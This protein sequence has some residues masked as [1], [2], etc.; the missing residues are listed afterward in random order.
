MSSPISCFKRPRLVC[1][2]AQRGRPH[3]SLAFLEIHPG[4][5]VCSCEIICPLVLQTILSA[6]QQGSGPD[7]LGPDAE[8]REEWGM[9]G[10]RETDRC[11]CVT[12]HPKPRCVAGCLIKRVWVRSSD[13][14]Q[15][16][17]LAISR[18]SAGDTHRLATQLPSFSPMAGVDPCCPQ[19]LLHRSSLLWAWASSHCGGL[20]VGYISYMEA[21]GWWGRMCPK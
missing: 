8:H 17:E 5:H 4:Q 14:A 11:C 6:P 12:N 3:L 19:E 10:T 2:S 7:R 20:K 18:T 15:Q 1:V 9:A 13:R 16:G 21:Q